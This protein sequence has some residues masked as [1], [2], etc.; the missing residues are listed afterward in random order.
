MMAHWL[1][2]RRPSFSSSRS[3]S[4]P[5]HIHRANPLAKNREILPHPVDDLATVLLVYTTLEG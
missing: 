4:L 1:V 2:L 3:I 5:E